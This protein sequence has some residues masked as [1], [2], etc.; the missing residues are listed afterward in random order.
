MILE[1]YEKENH[2]T[3][4]HSLKK[5]LVGDSTQLIPISHISLEEEDW[6]NEFLSDFNSY[7]SI[8]AEAQ[9][10][11]SLQ[12]EEDR[13]IMEALAKRMLKS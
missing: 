5:F 3:E 7:H 11:K 10:I 4:D 9:L 6:T 12:E 2:A 13:E 1:N 8:E